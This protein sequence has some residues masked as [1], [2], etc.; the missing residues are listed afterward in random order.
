MVEI[1]ICVVE[2][3]MGVLRTSIYYVLV[4]F[5][6]EDNEGNVAGF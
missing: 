4:Q 1:G 5:K 2:I 6:D 3:G